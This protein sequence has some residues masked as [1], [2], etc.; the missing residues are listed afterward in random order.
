M[1]KVWATVVALIALVLVSFVGARRAGWWESAQL[2]TVAPPPSAT[3]QR[4]ETSAARLGDSATKTASAAASADC[5]PMQWKRAFAAATSERARRTM[6]DPDA[7]TALTAA[8]L[9]TSGSAVLNDSLYEEAHGEGAAAMTTALRLGADEPLVQWIAASG[10]CAGIGEDCD[11]DRAVTRLQQLDPDNAAVWL[12][13]LA[14]AIER[15][16]DLPTQEALL[17]RAARADHYRIHLRE[18]GSVMY[19]ALDELPPLAVSA[20]AQKAYAAASDVPATRENLIGVAAMNTAMAN[21]FPS[22]SPIAELCEQPPPSRRESCIGLLAHMAS[23]SEMIDQVIGLHFGV[24][25]VANTSAGVAWRERLRRLSWLR[26]HF[27]GENGQPTP[28]DWHLRV[29]A[30]G[31]MPAAEAW[32]VERG[33]RVDPPPGWLPDNPMQRALIQTGRR[34]PRATPPPAPDPR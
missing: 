26:H 1:R 12:A 6:V 22:I 17:R 29:F 33:Q 28:P 10:G 23:G 15:G 32:L 8:F 9:F 7:R 14:R 5:D 21:G 31:E 25:L 27:P 34:P 18:L 11:P 30:Q 19:A 2:A 3:A 4:D 13:S 16:D 20:C 24:P